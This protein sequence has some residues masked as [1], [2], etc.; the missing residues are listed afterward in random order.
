MRLRKVLLAVFIPVEFFPGTTR[1]LY[2]QFAL[3][4]SFAVVISTFNA[5]TLT[6]A[7]SSLLLRQGQEPTGWLAKIFDVINRGI[8][9]M[10]AGYKKALELLTNFKL[11]VL[12]VF[13]FLLAITV[14]MYQTVPSAFLPD[15]DQ[16]YL[17]LPT[18][19]CRGFLAHRKNLP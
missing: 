8:D 9:G 11:I 4:I 12:G 3:T 16:G 1:Q 17:T 19:E 18:H 14:W 13:A 10:R 6:P 5:L 2:Q 7:L 15:E